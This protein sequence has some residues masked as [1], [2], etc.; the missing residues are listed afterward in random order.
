[1]IY[2]NIYIYNDI[3]LS[4]FSF[5]PRIKIKRRIWSFQ[6][7]CSVQ[8]ESCVCMYLTSW[9]LQPRCLLLTAVRA[10][11]K[12]PWDC[13]NVLLKEFRLNGWLE[14]GVSSV[15]LCVELRYIIE[16]WHFSRTPRRHL[17]PSA[18][19]L[20]Y[21][22]V[23]WLNGCDTYCSMQ[24]K[25]ATLTDRS[26]FPAWPGW[27]QWEAAHDRW[28]GHVWDLFHPRCPRFQGTLDCLQMPCCLLLLWS[29][30][31]LGCIYMI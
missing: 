14:L 1:M 4:F 23:A 27:I 24:Q 30:F 21:A 26:C 7:T 19:H 10:G 20:E 9:L 22:V 31:T 18:E 29:F 15:V 8:S 28:R 2:I 11:G 5:L 16:T 17:V 25:I 12:L 13:E 6:A 3:D